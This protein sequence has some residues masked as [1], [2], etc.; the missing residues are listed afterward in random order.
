VPAPTGRVTSVA[1]VADEH[2]TTLAA[3]RTPTLFWQ[4]LDK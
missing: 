2:D 3:A 1:T 4:D